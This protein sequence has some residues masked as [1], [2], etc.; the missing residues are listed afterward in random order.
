MELKADGAVNETA[1]RARPDTNCSKYFFLASSRHLIQ[2]LSRWTQTQHV[3]RHE[4]EAT[5]AL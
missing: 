1:V 4:T 5:H 3:T 2:E